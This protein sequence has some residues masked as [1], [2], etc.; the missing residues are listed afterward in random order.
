M[1]K[2]LVALSLFLLASCTIE[3]AKPVV[4]VSKGTSSVSSLR[5]VEIDG[6]EYLQYHAYYFEA[7]THKGNCKYCTERL[8]TR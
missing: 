8:K 7:I 5:V 3:E 1:K 6:C 4:K 2:L